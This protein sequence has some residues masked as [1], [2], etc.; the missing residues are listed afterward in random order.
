[1]RIA[2]WSPL[3]P[4]RSGI[5]DYSAELLPALARHLEVE[6]IV[7]DGWRRTGAMPAGLAAH[8]ERAF[9]GL[10]AAGRFDAVLY[11]LGNNHEYHASIYHALLEHP[12]AV[13]L[14]EVVL[15]HLVRD[16]T[17]SAG[18]PAAYVREMR[19]AYGLT[20][21][22]VARRC[23]ATGVPL[24]P[25]SYPLFERVVD[26]SLG[27]LVHNDFT[28]RRVLASR[29]LA[30]IATVPSH[31]SL[32]ERPL[33]G[34]AAA[35]AALGIAPGAFVVAS[36]GFV[37]PNK[38]PQE[39]LRAFARLRR[40][41]PRAMLLLVG[42]VSPHFDFAALAVP[43][44]MQGVTVTG[45]LELDRFLLH[46][47]AVD[48]AVNLRYPTAGET[49]ATFIRLLGLGKPVIVSR[50]GAFTEVPEGCCWPVDVDESEPEML[51]A[52]L[53]RLAAD[54]ELRRAMGE[55]ARRWVT[56]RHGVEGSARGYAELLR[57]VLAE[58]AAPF[59]A[60]PPLAPYGDEDVASDLLRAV[61]ADLCDL[62]VGENDGELLAPVAEAL[63]EL[64]G[65]I[66]GG[67]GAAGA[68]SGFSDRGG[69]GSPGGAGGAGG[70]GGFSS[71][72]GGSPGGAGGG[73]SSRGGGSPGGA[74]GG[75][76]SRGG[77]SPGGAGGGFSSRG[78]GSP[79]ARR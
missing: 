72:G 28:R 8:P 33:P 14:H 38:R 27:I 78:G 22:A 2:Y 62:G 39:V 68:S 13:V 65:R 64:T 43:E 46:M 45:R 16:L 36:F 63:V 49:S 34:P 17:L 31:L 44:L 76:S 12:G 9:A 10:A 19:Y 51:A 18:D 50:V 48:V 11:Q 59:R 53:E 29:P 66:G 6:L 37:T 79:G 25:W 75:F 23:V 54:G 58:R 5:A 32:G 74:G 69:R 55:N 71:R 70:G 57:Q 4:L 7:P 21:E 41:V 47:A 26:R 3:P 42:E 52:C 60:L 61:S 77:G 15:H 40:R 56:A 73:F 35:R 20:G 1:V 67:A 30:R 24:D